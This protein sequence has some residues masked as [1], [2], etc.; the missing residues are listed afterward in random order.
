MVENPRDGT[1]TNNPEPL[2]QDGTTN[3]GILQTLERAL[4]CKSGAPTLDG[5][6]SSSTTE[7]TS[8]TSTTRR[9][10]MLLVVKMLKDKTFKS[11]ADTTKPTRDGPLPTLINQPRKERLD[12]T[13]TTVSIS[14]ELSTSDQ[15]SQ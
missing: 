6:R 1:S 8:S 9:L 3:L 15:D 2:K 13:R 5:G 7:A 11:G 10:L 12:I 4:T 14:T